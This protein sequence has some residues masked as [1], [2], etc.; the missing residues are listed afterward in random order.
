MKNSTSK[1]FA[2]RVGSFFL[3]CTVSILIAKFFFPGYESAAIFLISGGVLAILL[4]QQLS[5]KYGKQRNRAK[6][7]R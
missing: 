2:I 6:K 3:V 1:D 4:L 7:Y 5:R